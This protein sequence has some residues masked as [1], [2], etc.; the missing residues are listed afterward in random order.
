M[1]LFASIRRNSLGLAIFAVLTAGL[2]ATT[3]QLTDNTIKNNILDAQIS[4]FNEILPADLY[5]NDLTK[6]T[7][8]LPADPLLGSEEG[9][10]IHIARKNGD[11][12]G[13]IFETIAPRGYNGNLDMLVAIDK[14]GT[15]TGS[16]VIS[17]KETPGLGDKVDLKKSK[18]ILGF[19]NKSLENPSLKGWGVKKDGGDFDQFTGATITPRAVV[20][21]VKNTLIYFD[22]HKDTLLAY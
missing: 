17:H 6:D 4:A 5:D 10:K 3:H 22:Q 15:V 21:A 8:Y 14:N 7:A 1:E 12:S 11:V 20:R 13:I 2:I 18:W 16:R 19:A 9:I